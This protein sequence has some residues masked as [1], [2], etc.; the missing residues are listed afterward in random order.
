MTLLA[1]DV[2]TSPALTV[3]DD[4]PLA[5]TIAIMLDRCIS[6]L[7]VV[8]AADELVGML[9]EGDLLHRAEVGTGERPRSGFWNFLRGPGL[10]ATEYVHAHSR[11]VEDLMSTAPVTVAADAPLEQVVEL[12]QKRRVR[13]LPVVQDGR[14]VGIVSRKDLLRAAAARMNLGKTGGTDAEILARLN[15][16]LTAQ[17]WFSA[18]NITVAVNNGIVSLAG[19]VTDEALRTALNVAASDAAGVGKVQDDLVVVEP[20]SGLVYPMV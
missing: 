19:A 4:A 10:N 15:K 20:S 8:N 11:R 9:T 12:M 3:R 7:P 6:G 13:R 2:M 1:R 5:E 18:R 17:P 16:E 14:V